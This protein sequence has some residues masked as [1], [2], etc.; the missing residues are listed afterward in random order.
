MGSLEGPHQSV[1]ECCLVLHLLSP[2]PITIS[3]F[4]SS[5]GVN[6]APYSHQGTVLS[7]QNLK[8]VLRSNNLFPHAI[9]SLY[10]RVRLADKV[11]SKSLLHTDEGHSFW[12]RELSL[13]P[14]NGYHFISLL[15]EQKRGVK[16]VR[17]LCNTL[18][19]LI[20]RTWSGIGQFYLLA[21]TGDRM[22]SQGCI[23]IFTYIFTNTHG[24]YSDL[25]SPHAFLIQS[26][27]QQH[28]HTHT[29][30]HTPGYKKYLLIYWIINQ[31][32]ITIN[33]INIITSKMFSGRQNLIEGNNIQY[34]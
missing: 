28:T 14:R 21:L 5:A 27:H 19:P 29:H 7:Q 24:S 30:T 2:H 8:P 26:L 25:G 17:T 31:F 9:I 10:L 11:G 23:M 18:F 12:G 20:L 33:Y 15:A 34:D 22:C 1:Y 16:E 6:K 32:Q 4:Y 3:T 13:S